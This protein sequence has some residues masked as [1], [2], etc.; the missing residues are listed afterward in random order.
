MR[1]P[2][3]VR[4]RFPLGP[5]TWPGGVERPPAKKRTGV[6][7]DTSWARRYPVRMAR[8]LLLDG[9]TKPV[10]QALASPTIDGLDRIQD[11]PAPVIFAA[12]HASHLDT[13]LLLT[14]LP[15]RFR[16]RAV[17][18]AAADYFFDKR[19][20]AA[21]NAF[22]IGAVPMERTKV[23]RRS[24]IEAGKL[25]EDGWSLV[26]FPEGGR[27]PLGWAQEF[28]GGAAYLAI[29][30]GVPVV[31]VH[32][33]GTRRVL[34]KGAKRLTPSHTN[35]TFGRALRPLEGEDSRQMAVRIEQAVAELADEQAHDWWTARR[36]AASGATASI[37]GPDAGA[38]R[39]SWALGEHKRGPKRDRWPA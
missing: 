16:H 33:E 23:N 38:W 3:P 24:A 17:V 6:D 32:I 4:P 37:T 14:S 39:R 19:W 22:S 8:A 20:K 29:R 36:R 30:T 18:V 26:I 9:V 31:P 27:S 34:K 21:F 7:Y 35:L 28:K 5:A 2:I 13:P 12:N 25:I 15:P 1:L 11:L 10:V